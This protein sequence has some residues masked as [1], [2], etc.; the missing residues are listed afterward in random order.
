MRLPKDV[1]AL[2]AVAILPS[3]VIAMFTS[4]VGR[5][6]PRSLRRAMLVRTTMPGIFFI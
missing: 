6:E 4:T 1:T 3:A 5:A 2:L